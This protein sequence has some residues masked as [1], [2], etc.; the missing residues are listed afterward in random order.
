[1][2][3]SQ[4]DIRRAVAEGKIAFDPPLDEDQWG[5]ASVDLRLGFRFTK[6]KELT[7]FKVSVAKG[8]QALADAG[9]WVTKDLRGADEFGPETCVLKPGDFVL[10][11]T[12]ERIKIPSNLIGLVEGRSTYARVG[13]SM[14]Q[15]APWIQPGWSGPIVLEIRNSGPLTIELTPLID[16]PC[17]LTFL[18]LTKPLPKRL[19]YG[20]RATDVYQDQDHPLKHRRARSTPTSSKKRRP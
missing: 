5:E 20:S 9:F 14:H 4:P 6:L 15:T 1:M 12:H 18:R 19:S 7:D 10:A 16:R 17:Q 13:L 8:L 2:I 3:L 11:M